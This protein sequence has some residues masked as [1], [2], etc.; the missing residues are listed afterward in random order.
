MFVQRPLDSDNDF[1]ALLHA[2]PSPKSK[3]YTEL[4]SKLSLSISEAE[5]KSFKDAEYHNF[6]DR[7]VSFCFDKKPQLE[8]GAIH[9]YND[10][11]KV[12]R[13]EL[14]QFYDK[15]EDKQKSKPFISYFE[16]NYDGNTIIEL[17]YGISKR[18]TMKDFVHKFAPVEPEKGG[19]SMQRSQLNCWFKYPYYK[20]MVEFNT[21]D[22]EEDNATWK[23]LIISDFIADEP[24][25]DELD[26][27]S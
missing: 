20:F 22:F 27:Y 6:K 14:H 15:P 18:T 8:L 25:D 23:E 1:I 19:G 11:S 7:G 2:N 9:I 4:L 13:S 16:C 21:R 5:V 12:Y 10:M 26:V 24:S 17:P 3:R